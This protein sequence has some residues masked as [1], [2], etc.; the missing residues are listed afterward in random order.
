MNKVNRAE[1]RGRRLEK[2]CERANTSTN[3]SGPDDNRVFCF[4]LNDFRT[5][6]LIELCK[7]CKANVIYAE[8]IE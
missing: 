7:N 8:P 3:E 4:G 5:D 1:L 6:E 2:F